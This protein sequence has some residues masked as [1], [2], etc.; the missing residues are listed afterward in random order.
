MGIC[1]LLL[2]LQNTVRYDNNLYFV[3]SKTF[4]LFIG[5]GCKYMY[6]SKIFFFEE[7][8]A[9]SNFS[10]FCQSLSLAIV[11]K[12]EYKKKRIDP[13]SGNLGQIIHRI[14]DMR[15][16]LLDTFAL[17]CMLKRNCRAS[18][19]YL[20]SCIFICTRLLFY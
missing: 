15:V 1:L 20:L 2:H 13:T 3:L 16:S 17:H 4:E 6:I 14:Y 7:K 12:K 10:V 11:L 5:R 9:D 18:D 19:T 8:G